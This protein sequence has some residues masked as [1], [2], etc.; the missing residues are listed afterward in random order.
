MPRGRESVYASAD[1]QVLGG[2]GEGHES[3]QAS[4]D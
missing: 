2:M 3:L 4:D 1:D